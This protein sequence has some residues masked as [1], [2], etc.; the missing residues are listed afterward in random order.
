MLVM[1]AAGV[2]NV[3]WMAALGLVMAL[4]KLSTTPRLSRAVGLA[5]LAAGIALPLGSMA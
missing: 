5:L 1:F 3:G 2:M 4:E